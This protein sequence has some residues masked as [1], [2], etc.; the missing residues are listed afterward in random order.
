[1][2]YTLVSGTV[3]LAMILVAFN[4]F[5]YPAKNCPPP[6]LGPENLVLEPDYATREAP[7]AAE[8]LQYESSHELSAL[9]NEQRSEEEKEGDTVFV[10][11]RELY[12]GAKAEFK[13][14][15]EP[16]LPEDEV[17]PAEDAGEE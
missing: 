7:M 2:K 11:G 12:V 10:D 14:T 8:K 15:G 1:M 4:A 3:F 6:L 17:T 9:L 13:P 5:G 16:I